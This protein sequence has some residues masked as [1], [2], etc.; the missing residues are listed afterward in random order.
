M[1]MNTGYYYCYDY[2]YDDDYYY[3][4]IK[5]GRIIQFEKERKSY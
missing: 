4:F 2:Y 5:F 3:F 1:N